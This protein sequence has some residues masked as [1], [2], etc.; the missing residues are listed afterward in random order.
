MKK[1]ISMIRAICVV[2]AAML[3][4]SCSSPGV[5]EPASYDFGPLRTQTGSA[6][7]VLSPVRVAEVNAPAWLDSTQMIYRLAYSNDQQLRSYAHSRWAMPPARLFEQRLKARIAQAGG[8]VVSALDGAANLPT[9]RIDAEDFSQVFDHPTHGN[10]QVTVRASLMHGSRLTAQKT[11]VRHYPAP[12]ADARG[13]AAALAAAS[14]AVITDMM[15]WLSGQP[16]H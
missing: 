9:V 4:F 12:S 6:L 3:T 10:A 13:G 1:Q 7:P 14:D 11:F 2:L 5:Q 16:L 15:L 8:V